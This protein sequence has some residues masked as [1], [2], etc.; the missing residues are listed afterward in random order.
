[1]ANKSINAEKILKI[2]ALSLFGVAILLAFTGV[3]GDVSSSSS[4]IYGSITSSS[5]SP[6]SYFFR[7]CWD[8][9]KSFKELCISNKAM[10]AYGQYLFRSILHFVSFLVAFV[11][12]IVLTI[13]FSS[14]TYKSLSAKKELTLSRFFK[15]LI[16]VSVPYILMTAFTMIT[17]ISNIRRDSPQYSR[18]EVTTFGWG[19][20][21]LIVSLFLAF[22]ACFIQEFANKSKEQK[23]SFCV[24][25]LATV[26][27][28]F[29]VVF[30]AS[31]TLHSSSVTQIQSSQSSGS[32]FN[33]FITALLLTNPET[34]NHITSGTKALYVFAVML[35]FALMIC[36]LCNLLV[37]EKR[38]RISLS[39]VIIVLSIISGII[40]Y[41]AIENYLK[42]M[43]STS[44]GLD[45]LA[46][47]HVVNIVFGVISC[48]SSI[49]SLGLENKT[50]EA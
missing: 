30:G 9:L 31:S 28:L 49:V 15:I 36:I 43:G 18:V 41:N 7:E 45:V 35:T 24:S 47:S 42:E 38:S 22:V 21:L 44:Q 12:V 19:S 17:N 3:F 1:M 6:L 27:M 5:V 4:N 29:A 48:A 10:D 16:G 25:E 2:I 34:G 26:L 46:P 13:V 33:S 40:G 8:E 50:K 39:I 14:S 37:K 32:V 20:V 11:G 23:A